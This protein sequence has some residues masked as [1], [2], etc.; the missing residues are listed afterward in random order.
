MD[1][2]QSFEVFYKKEAVP[3]L[4]KH[5]GYSNVMQVPKLVKVVLNV[6]MSE[7]LQ[8]AKLLDVAAAELAAISGQ[9]PVLTKAKKSIASFKLRAG[10]AIGVCVTLRKQKMYEFLN[11]L[12]NVALPRV[13]DFKGVPTG[14]FDKRGNYT[15]GLTE[16]IIFPEI[17]YDK[18]DRIRGMNVTICTTAKT[19]QEAFELLKLL[20]MPFKK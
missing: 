7:A 3:H 17:N 2:T 4:M 9:R 8:N 19:D 11:R 1:K 6:S 5:F 10:Q 18:V 13:R 14:S 15:L 12:V 20:G 16:Q